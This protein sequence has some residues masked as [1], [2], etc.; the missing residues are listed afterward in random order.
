MP[1]AVLG[2]FTAEAALRDAGAAAVLASLDELLPLV[3]AG[4]A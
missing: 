1:V 4:L 3:A 2:G